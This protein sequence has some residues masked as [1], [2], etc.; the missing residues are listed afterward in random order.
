MPPGAS[1]AMHVV[2]TELRRIEVDD[3]R[4]ARH[5]D[6]ASHHVRGNQAADLARTKPL[7]HPVAIR[8]A[9]CPRGCRPRARCVCTGGETAIRCVVSCGRTR[10][11]AAGSSRASKRTQQFELAAV[12]HRE[13]GLLDRLDGDIRGREIQGSP[14][15]TCTVGPC[16][17]I[18]GGTVALKSSVC[19]S[20][21][22]W[23]RIFS[24]SGRK[25][26]SSMRSASSR[27]TI[28]SSFS[29]SVRRLMW[30]STRPGV[31]T[32]TSAPRRSFSIWLANRLAAVDGHA[33]QSPAVREFDH[34]AAHLHGQFAGG[35]ENQRPGRLAAMRFQHLDDGIANAAVLPVPVRACPIRS[36]PSMAL[37]I[38]PA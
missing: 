12:F 7:H 32:I 22:H 29:S 18:G 5:V 27:T 19:R 17:W 13:I 28:S 30:S 37:G 26:M 38:M 21:G 4:D 23:R 1:D 15:R 16:R 20:A 3:M 11:P 6:A 25:P 2:V 33:V 10:S 34:F 35:N 14:V 24:M 36:I 8:S 31:P 9:T